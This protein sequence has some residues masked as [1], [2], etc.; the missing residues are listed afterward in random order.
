MLLLIMYIVYMNSEEYRIILL[1]P[2]EPEV[3]VNHNKQL[4]DSMDECNE[5]TLGLYVVCTPL[6][7]CFHRKTYQI[8]N[9]NLWHTFHWYNIFESAVISWAFFFLFYWSVFCATVCT[10][11]PYFVQ[12]SAPAFGR[13]V[14]FHNLAPFTFSCFEILNRFPKSQSITKFG[15]L[16]LAK[17]FRTNLP[18][19]R[20][21]GLPGI[22]RLKLFWSA[23]LWLTTISSS[24]IHFLCKIFIS[25]SSIR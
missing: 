24:I 4:S 11:I 2:S 5:K 10:C 23:C 9:K 13:A 15:K 1:R 17:K 21:Q 18:I 22:R 3:E 12:L 25:I 8:S 20:T 7:C 6:W 19:Y 16:C 14:V